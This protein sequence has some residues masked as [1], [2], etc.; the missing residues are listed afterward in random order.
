MNQFRTLPTFGQDPRSVAEVVNGIMNGKTN[1][2]GTVTLAT[3]NA[4]TTTI[5]DERIGGVMRKVI[6]A[7]PAVTAYDRVHRSYVRASR[8]ENWDW[9]AEYL[10]QRTL[11]IASIY[12]MTAPEVI[13]LWMEWLN[14][15]EEAMY[16]NL[17]GQGAQ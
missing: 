7:H 15:T 4:T 1:N 6:I 14:E 9:W 2:T 13:K 17:Y 12:E 11:Q 5:N 16:N 10:E 8:S 3:G